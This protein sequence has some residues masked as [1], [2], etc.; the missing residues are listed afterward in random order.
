MRFLVLKSAPMADS[1][2]ERDIYNRGPHPRSRATRPVPDALLEEAAASLR[3]LAWQLIFEYPVVQRWEEPDDV[4][5][6]ALMRLYRALQQVDIQSK[7][8][9]HRLAALQIRR[10]LIDMARRHSSPSSMAAN[11]GTGDAAREALELSDAEPFE[12]G[13][14][15]CE[16]TEF[17]E[18]V[19]RLA[20]EHRELFDLFWYAQL[21]TD[22]V[23]RLFG[24]SSRT[25]QRRWKAAQ[26]ELAK[27][28][29]ARE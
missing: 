4:V 7:L 24:V 16:W 6:E 29:T 22:E 23:A 1:N 2:H 19:G 25:V 27:V 12:S 20:D 5:Q 11:H 15:L 28:W 9:F 18:M 10:T 13:L 3:R 17:H 14:E 8:H 26:L 21:S